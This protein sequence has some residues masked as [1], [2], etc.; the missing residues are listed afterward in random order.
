[1]FAGLAGAVFAPL[2]MFIAPESFPF[3]QSILFLLAVMVGGAGWVFGPLVGAVVTVMLPELLSGMAE[4]RLLIFG[5]L[6]L[7]V[8]WLAPEGIIGTIARLVRRTDHDVAGGGDFDLKAFLGHAGDS[9]ADATGLVV[10][11]IGI[12]F[13]GIRAASA[14]GFVARP[15]Q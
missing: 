11:D 13:G 14:V 9:A 4:Y 12:S 10:R 6:L 7:V 8:L 2:M 1:M 15:G 5:A 3:S